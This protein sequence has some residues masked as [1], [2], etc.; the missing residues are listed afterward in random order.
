M[1]AAEQLIVNSAVDH[2]HQSGVDH[3]F[4]L[5]KTGEPILAHHH[6]QVHRLRKLRSSAKAA[7]HFI[8]VMLKVSD[9]RFLKTPRNRPHRCLP[10]ATTSTWRPPRS[11]APHPLKAYR[12]PWSNVLDTTE[13]LQKRILGK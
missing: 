3:H 1:K 7:I 12:G 13:E 9:I 5:M 10:Q 2:G 8:K 11:S 4:C 6:H